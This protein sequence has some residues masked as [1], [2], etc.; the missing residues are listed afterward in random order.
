MDSYTEITQ[1]GQG[2]HVICRGNIPGEKRRKGSVEMYETKRFFVM[3]GNVIDDAHMDVEERPEQLASV[4]NKYLGGKPKPE[5]KSTTPAVEN[6][7]DDDE[8]IRKA[9]E[10]SNGEL[11]RD[12]MNGSWQH[13]YN[14]QSEAELAL[15]NMLAFWTGRD[16]QAM[17][18]IYRRSGM[19]RKKWDEKR[20][21]GTYG[22][23]TIEE[24][25]R[26]CSEIY[27]PRVP[28]QEQPVPEPPEMDLGYDQ[29]VAQ[30]DAGQYGQSNYFDVSSD[31]GRSQFFSNKYRGK[32]NWCSDMKSWLI[33]DG[34]RWQADRT[35]Q[36]M[37]LAK[38]T[39][40]EMILNAGKAISN[41][42]GEEEVKKAKQVFKELVKA[43]SERGIK[44]MVELAKSD[45]PITV[46]CLDVDPYLLN[47]QNGVVDLRTGKLQPHKPEYYMT[48]IARANY[49]PKKE[50]TKFN[51][52]LK[53]ITCD[54]DELSGYFQ[55]ICG[56]AAIGKVFTE[57]MCI[58]YGAGSNGKST[59]LNCISKVFGDY[60]CSINPEVL[61]SQKD[62][63][64]LAGGVSVEGKRFVTAM[65]IEEGKR[66]SGAMLKKLA[67][68]DPITERPLYQNERIFMPSH[69]LIMALNFL[70]KISSTDLG[71]WR[72]I[73]VV[74]FKAQFQGRQEIKDFA[75]VLFN[76]D[77]DA[78]L[79]WIV[80]GAIK[81]IKNDCKIT[82]PAV[83]AEATAQYKNAE[84]WLGNFLQEC[85]EMG[86]YEE[87]GGSLFDAYKEWC[88]QNNESYVR[89]SRDFASALEL[90]GFEKR[91]TM[92]GSVWKGLRLIENSNTSSMSKY[93]TEKYRQSNI[94]DDDDLDKYTRSRM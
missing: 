14:S 69:T 77:A 64:Q 35:L 31:L 78:I 58:F 66:L 44:S 13:R 28:R 90:Q 60:A 70:P 8:I 2:I 6:N 37:Q 29:Y 72:R 21:G 33:W 38:E 53:D 71:T 16:V 91:R 79:S 88:G 42:T 46:D 63:R 22:T 47:C 48:K 57:G 85:C 43:K 51:Q 50:F 9:S 74:P 61:M 27:T 7:L 86:E 18:R 11:F 39:I 75:T 5:R 40:E 92:H 4:Y 87:S 80:E 52:F 12:L 56:M 62:G 15:C 55:Q 94:V 73:A 36:V 20:P 34:K 65:E 83:V 81:Y 45:L 23:M 49:E 17:D 54:D 24:A 89:R 3:T 26:G 25:A 30:V 59:F 32:L 1:S 10:A 82:L 76:S 84:D 68:A 93:R 19:Y 67:S 41:A